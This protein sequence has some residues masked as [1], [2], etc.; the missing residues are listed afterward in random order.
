M[1][2]VLDI[3]ICLR[4]LFAHVSQFQY[5]RDESIMKGFNAWISVRNAIVCNA[6]DLKNIRIGYIES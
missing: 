6:V 1:Q 2:Q 5:P 3:G 4:Y